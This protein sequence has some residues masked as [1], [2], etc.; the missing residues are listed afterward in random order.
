MV[1]E[2][3]AK[4]H[5]NWLKIATARVQTDRQ[6]SY[7]N[8]SSAV[9]YVQ[10]ADKKLEWLDTMKLKHK[11]STMAL[12]IT[13]RST[14]V[15]VDVVVVVV[16][17]FSGSAILSLWYNSLYYRTIEQTSFNTCC[18]RS[19]SLWLSYKRCF[20]SLLLHPSHFTL[21][22]LQTSSSSSSSSWQNTACLPNKQAIFQISSTLAIFPGR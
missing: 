21:L 11:R 6:T 3:C 12:V 19:S 17:V 4:F 13:P 1:P 7:E 8:I 5:Q 10:L 14:R 15:V 20:T 18:C 9:H 2:V 22:L 16:V